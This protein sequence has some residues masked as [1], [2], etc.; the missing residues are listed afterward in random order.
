M[1]FTKI[2]PEIW[3]KIIPNP[4][5]SVLD[6]QKFPLP[7]LAISK[8]PSEQIQKLLSCLTPNITDIK[9]I[10]VLPTPSEVL[11]K[12]L[13]K[14]PEIGQSQSF[15]CEHLHGRKGLR[16][17]LWTISY[18]LEVLKIRSIK[19]LWA[20]AQRN[21]DFLQKEH[22]LT[23][24]IMDLIKQVSSVLSNL[25]WKDKIKGFAAKLPPEH[26]T[27]YLT[28]KWLT[29]EHENQMLHLLQKEITL[30]NPKSSTN[31]TDTYFFQILSQHHRD[32]TYDVDE[33]VAWV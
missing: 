2:R 13:L 29:D 30:Q 33:G 23:N 22:P 10:I 32:G 31:I 20:S 28:R 5:L 11:L 26:L 14:C 12:N 8:S 15:I 24:N 17:P 3:T 9:E 6:I 16:V 19:L 1:E 21:L 27:S 4:N 18:W 7:E 25:S